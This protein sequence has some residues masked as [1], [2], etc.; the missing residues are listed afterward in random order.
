MKRYIL[1]SLLVHIG[2][3][4]VFSL[5]IEKLRKEDVPFFFDIAMASPGGKGTGA[6]GSMHGPRAYGIRKA[7]KNL[8]GTVRSAAAA[9]SPAA[10]SSPRPA[11]EKSA[12]TESVPLEDPAAWEMPSPESESSGDRAAGVE[13]RATGGGGRETGGPGSGWED[14]RAGESGSGT[15]TGGTGSSSGGAPGYGFGGDASFGSA[16]GPA[17]LKKE[18]PVYPALARRLGREGLVVLRLTIDE[19]GILTHLEIVED[20]GYGFSA[21]AAEAARKSRFAPAR[22]NGRPTACRALLPVRFE[23]K[24]G[25]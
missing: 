21:A 13:E 20:P 19:H 10:A 8:R 1:L 15:G 11:G 4:I 23:L 2:G 5:D 22:V 18:M 9:E 25:S 16:R 6:G 17:F 7:G 3:G 24:G 12:E 14:P